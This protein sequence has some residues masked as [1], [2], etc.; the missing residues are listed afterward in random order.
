MRNILAT[1]VS[2][3]LFLVVGFMAY[4]YYPENHFALQYQKGA[5]CQRRQD[6]H[7]TAELI[8]RY[9]GLKGHYPL[10]A[11]P[12]QLPISV[13]LSEETLPRQFLV[14]PPP[15]ISG[16]LVPASRLKNTLQEGLGERVHLPADPQTAFAWGSRYYLYQLNGSGDYHLSA[17]LFSPTEQSLKKGRYHHRFQVGSKASASEKTQQFSEIAEVRL[18]CD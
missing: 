11:D 4:M 6:I 8:E 18:E 17:T 14:N 9:F 12:T 7:R 15:E 5:D 16:R 10:G 3:G 1:A 2:L 13:V